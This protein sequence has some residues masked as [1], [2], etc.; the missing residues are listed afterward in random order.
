MSLTGLKGY[1]KNLN[2][3]PAFPVYG[4]P[5]VHI[6]EVVREIMKGIILKDHVGFCAFTIFNNLRLNMFHCFSL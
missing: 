5:M 4:D 1:D 6:R 3:L 2:I